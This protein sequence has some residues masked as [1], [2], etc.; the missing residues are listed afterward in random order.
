MEVCKAAFVHASSLV[1]DEQRRLQHR[2]TKALCFPGSTLHAEFCKFIYGTCDL[3]E[4]PQ[5]SRLRARLKFIT[6]I[7]RPVE[8]K[9]QLLQRNTELATNTSG[10][11]IS[12]G[13]REEQ[14]QRFIS[15]TPDGRDLLADNVSNCRTGVK[16]LAE[17]GLQMHP[18]ISSVL[19]N[20]TAAVAGDSL[21]D[22]F[23]RGAK[24]WGVVDSAVYH[25][26]DSIYKPVCSTVGDDEPPPAPPQEPK[27][28]AVNDRRGLMRVLQTLAV[29]HVCLRHAKIVSVK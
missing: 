29:K 28:N 14:L 8:N 2:L 16:M 22:A 25:T 6:V 24:N 5:L 15:E 4:L 9:H 12:Y 10:A 7:E 3:G 18:T 23:G 11:Y 1:S 17:L 21:Q 13:M 20:A 26:D 27:V 19:Q